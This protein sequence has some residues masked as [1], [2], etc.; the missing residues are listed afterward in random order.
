[1]KKLM[2]KLTTRETSYYN[3]PQHQIIVRNDG[4]VILETNINDV[5]VQVFLNY[6][7][8]VNFYNRSFDVNQADFLEISEKIIHNEI[9]FIKFEEDLKQINFV[10][11]D[12]SVYII[13]YTEIEH[14]PEKISVDYSFKIYKDDLKNIYKK[15]A[16]KSM[17]KET[18]KNRLHLNCLAFNGSEY[19]CTDVRRLH[20][21]KIKNI[22]EL[23]S[24]I[25]I[26]QNTLEI[27]L[28]LND[29]IY[30]DISNNK[31]K[32][33]SGVVC[34]EYNNNY[35]Y[36]DYSS[37]LPSHSSSTIDLKIKDK[38]E[39]IKSIKKL[40]GAS[41]IITTPEQNN[42]EIFGFDWESNEIKIKSSIK[43]I[44]EKIILNNNNDGQT[45]F[46]K[47]YFIEM[48]EAFDENELTIQLNGKIRPALILTD[49][50]THIVMPKR[51]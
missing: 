27:L 29:K 46:D 47:N 17:M 45:M 6:C 35:E 26:G 3:K 23:S 21:H 24:P 40:V 12:E 41:I 28:E 10:M 13:G 38:K 42:L 33:K 51:K 14:K 50:D 19:T 49:N 39:F 7:N 9:G 16:I 15:K 43:I 31:V 2:K 30:C 11:Q 8:Q 4:E 18:K 22:Q 32:M 48:L 25:T 34:I 37:I 1:M 5:K 36:P 44:K 20:I